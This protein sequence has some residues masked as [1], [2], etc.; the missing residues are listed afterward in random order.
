MNLKR[1]LSALVVCC[2][3]L[4]ASTANAGALACWVFEFVPG[5]HLPHPSLDYIQ[6]GHTYYSDEFDWV[7]GVDQDG[8]SELFEAYVRKSV[9]PLGPGS[10]YVS[11]CKMSGPYGGPKYNAS[12]AHERFLRETDGRST[13][14]HW[15]PSAAELQKAPPPLRGA[16]IYM[17][18]LAMP[19]SQR[20][21]QTGDYGKSQVFKIK[22]EDSYGVESKEFRPYLEA[23]NI[24][25]VPKCFKARTRERLDAM[26][27]DEIDH[28]KVGGRIYDIPFTASGASAD[29]TPSV[30]PAPKPKPPA[31]ASSPGSLTV[32]TDT[33]LRDAGKAWDEQVKKTLAEEAKRKVQLAVKQAQT[34][35]KAKADLEAFLKARRK[36]GSAQ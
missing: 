23:N 3:C 26:V 28:S 17:Q 22:P 14:L 5:Q 31:A 7:E 10:V 36:Q 15:T 18:C 16:P 33:G 27:I 6:N 1:F 29:A 8:Y 30:Q 34:D 24:R 19:S 13:N 21:Y 35:A 32:K 2:A 4:F 11:G 25:A 12:K 9:K 20:L